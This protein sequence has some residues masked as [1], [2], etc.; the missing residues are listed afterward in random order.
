MA[1]PEN[2]VKDAWELVEG[3]CEC[4]RTSHQHPEGRCN[5]FIMGKEGPGGLGCVGSARYR[6][7]SGS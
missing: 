2:V 3:R 6:R 7:H 1:F 5:T 4:N